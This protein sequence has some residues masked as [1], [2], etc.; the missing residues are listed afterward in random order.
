MLYLGTSGLNYEDWVGNFCPT[1]MPKRE[2]L[3]YYARFH[4]RNSAKQSTGTIR[5]LQMLLD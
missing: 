2:W 4:G 1:G 5:H 3:A